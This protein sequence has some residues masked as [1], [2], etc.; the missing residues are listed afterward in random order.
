MKIKYLIENLLKMKWHFVEMKF[1]CQN[2]CQLEANR[3][4]LLVFLITS[5]NLMI[6][7]LMKHWERFFL[8]TC[9]RLNNKLIITHIMAIIICSVPP[10][11]SQHCCLLLSADGSVSAINVSAVILQSELKSVNSHTFF[12]SRMN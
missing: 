1:Y 3:I 6:N 10:L 7:S 4:C 11:S 2:S 5:H 9:W 12:F 8:M